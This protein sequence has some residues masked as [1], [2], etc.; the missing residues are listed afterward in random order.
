MVET[1]DWRIFYSGDTKPNQN[2]INYGQ[3]VDLLIHEATLEDGLEVDAAMKNHTTTGQAINIGLKINAWR[4]CLTHFSPRYVKVSEI[5]KNHFDHKVMNA[6]D[7]FRLKLSDFE[8]AYKTLELYK[9]FD[10]L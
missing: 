5:T 4:I 3:G 2:Y 9:P 7:H 10:E 8:W 6:I 1:E